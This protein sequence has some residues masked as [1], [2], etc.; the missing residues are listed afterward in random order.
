MERINYSKQDMPK[1]GLDFC[2]SAWKFK[3]SRKLTV[4]LAIASWFSVGD[5]QHYIGLRL[6]KLCVYR[7][8]KFSIY[9]VEKKL[10]AVN[11]KLYYPVICTVWAQF[12]Y[13]NI[14]AVSEL[15][16]LF[17]DFFV[18]WKQAVETW[19]IAPGER[20]TDSLP[21]NLPANKH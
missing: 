8:D 12:T 15:A 5:F 4:D 6:C 14:L 7:I 16:G 21:P 13:G 11:W 17:C 1:T 18:L 2:F 19:K 10:R 20:K 9:F 3:N